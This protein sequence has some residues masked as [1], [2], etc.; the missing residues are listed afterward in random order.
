MPFDPAI[1]ANN[2]PL[3]SAVMRGQLTSLKA[4]I[5][6]GVPGP[7]GPPGQQGKM[8]V[9]SDPKALQAMM[10]QRTPKGRR[11]IRAPL[12]RKVTMGLKARREK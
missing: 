3:S 12:A 5:D 10:G 4:L 7:Q 8:T 11:A 1:P 2:A 9:R 6:A